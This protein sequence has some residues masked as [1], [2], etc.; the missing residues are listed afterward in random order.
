MKVK[1]VDGNKIVIEHEVQGFNGEVLTIET[2]LSA[3]DKVC[4]ECGRS[5][6]MRVQQDCNEPDDAIFYICATCRFQF[7]TDKWAERAISD[8]MLHVAYNIVM[9]EAFSIYI[10]AMEAKKG[11]A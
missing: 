2:P 11:G 10:K 3:T 7:Y 5:H 6:V 1:D 8:E 4:P 9:G